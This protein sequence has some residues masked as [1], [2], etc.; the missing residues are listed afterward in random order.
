MLENGVERVRITDFG[1]ARAVDD[2]SVTQRGAV[3]GTPQ[4]MAPEQ[5]Q[6]ESVDQRA[7]LFA[8]GSTIYAMCTGRAPFRGDSGMAVIRQVCDVEPPSIRSINPDVPA[9]LEGIV[10]KLHAKD[11]AQRFQSAD[12]VADLLGRCLAHVQQPD[13]HPQPW[14]TDEPPVAARSDSP[15]MSSRWRSVSAAL[16]IVVL[17]GAALLFAPPGQ[18][19]GRSSRIPNR[20]QR[21]NL[22][23]GLLRPMRKCSEMKLVGKRVS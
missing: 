19:S 11:P 14:P 9:W 13:Q 1:L 4:Y 23:P 12:E 3:A 22:A 18:G 15:R 8:L 20:P 21:P 2:A 16:A 17:A 5:A 7:D 6:G 10:R